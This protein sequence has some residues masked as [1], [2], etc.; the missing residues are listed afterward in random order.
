[1][2]LPSCFWRLSQIEILKFESGSRVCD[3]T[4]SAF[5][6]CCFLRSVSIPA[7]VKFLRRYCFSECGPSRS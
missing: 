5:W 4:E 2:S 6:G 3:I 1:V 7:S